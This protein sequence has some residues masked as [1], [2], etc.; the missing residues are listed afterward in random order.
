VL[1]SSAQTPHLPFQMV[2]SPHP[3]VLIAEIENCDK[4]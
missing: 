4:V 1:D 3:I 2:L